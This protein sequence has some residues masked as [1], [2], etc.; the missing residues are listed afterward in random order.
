MLLACLEENEFENNKCV[1]Q[2]GVLQK[3]YAT[4]TKNIHH[5]HQQQER[6]EPT[7]YS[8]NLSYKQ[9]GYMLRR[10]PTV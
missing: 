4:Y 9:I 10:Y 7:P 6:I 3:C 2:F 8:K 5:L 1:P